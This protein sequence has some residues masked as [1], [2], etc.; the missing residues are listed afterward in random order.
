MSNLVILFCLV[1]LHASL[2]SVFVFAGSISFNL[3]TNTSVH[4]PLEGSRSMIRIYD[5][6]VKVSYTTL[7]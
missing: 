5:S 2:A 6:G 3:S 4:C 1:S 7:L